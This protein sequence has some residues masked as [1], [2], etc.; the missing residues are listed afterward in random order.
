ML[1]NRHVPAAYEPGG[2]VGL[3]HV[4]RTAPA[5][6]WPRV[7]SRWR[8]PWR[9][10]RPRRATCRP[11]STSCTTRSPCR[12]RATALPTVVTLHDVSHLDLP[13][14]SPAAAPLPPTGPTTARRAPPMW[15]S[16]P[17]SSRRAASSTRWA[18]RRSASRWCRWARP[19]AFHARRRPRTPRARLPERFCSTPPTSGPTRTTTGWWKRWRSRATS[20][21]CSPASTTAAGPVLARAERA[22]RGRAVPR[23]SRGA[24][25]A[26]GA[27]P[28]ASGLIPSLHEGFGMPALE[29]M[30][31]GCPAAVAGRGGARRR[32]PAAPR[33]RSIPVPRTRSPMRWSGSARRGARAR[34]RDAGLERARTFSWRAAAERHRSLY[35]RAAATSPPAARS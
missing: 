7:R 34:L 31:C 14:S 2:P 13:A 20:S 22:R 17:A 11:A 18:S 27:V 28:A 35:E 3:H 21:W 4:P 23:R 12:S 8:P 33:W 1:A 10:P 32:S 29:A 16:R 6:A 19:L 9:A 30:A 25:H 24:G 15:W 5:K 26:G